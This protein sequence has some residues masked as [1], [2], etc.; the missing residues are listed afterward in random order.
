[1]ATAP[2]K[3]LLYR[4]AP[5]W[6]LWAAVGGAVAIHLTAVALAQRHEAPPVE[7]PPNAP[8]V[9]EATLA[10]PE[11]TPPPEDIP[12]P[13]PPPP[14]EIKPEFVEERTPP[15]RPP[16]SAQQKFT[17]IKAQAM[18]MSRAK[19]LAVNAPRPQYPYEAR[20]RKITGSGVCVV[21]VDPGSGS[22][23]G[24]S[25][26]QSIGSP[27]LDNAALSAFRQWRFRPGTVSQVK[28]PITFT[29]TGASY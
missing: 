3:P 6:Q 11:A 27:I 1:M 22:V 9:V 18:T 16:P 5:Q 4:P 15:P 2:V 17:P 7:L 21:T 25:M 14:P 26:T 13:E 28:I 29:M 8:T 20:S 12:L 19:A 10:P 23:T 24:A